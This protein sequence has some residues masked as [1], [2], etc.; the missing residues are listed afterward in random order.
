MAARTNLDE[1][2]LLSR[3]QL[4]DLARMNGR[5]ALSLDGLWFL[6]VESLH[7]TDHAIAID[8]GVWRQFG[9]SEGKMLKRFLGLDTVT[10][11]E[12]ICR[13]YL[14]TPVF[15][16]LG[17]TAEVDGDRCYL[18]VTDCHPQKSRVKKKL[19]EFPCKTVGMAYFNGLL[20][21]LNPAIRF[22]CTIC[23][24]DEHPEDLWCRW[25][26]WFEGNGCGLNSNIQTCSR[27]DEG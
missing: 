2:Q 24:P 25:E 8:E 7:G 27:N 3:E 21:E 26:I 19:G 1:Y 13:I 4:M 14:L 23:P 9:A 22:A 5:F 17:A 16:N 6:G 10:T 11:L 15:G 20:T 18:S 12:D